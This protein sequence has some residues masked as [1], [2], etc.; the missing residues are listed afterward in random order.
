MNSAP[1]IPSDPDPSRCAA[2]HALGW[3]VSGNTIGMA[4]SVLLLRPQWHPGN[5]SY[6]HWVP[7]HLNAQLYGW[8]ALPLVGWLMSMYET[9]RSKARPWAPAAIW[10]WT[11]ALA[12]SSFRWLE[13]ETSGKIFLDWRNASLWSFLTALII[14]WSVLAVS[15]MD[16]RHSWSK[17]RRF[18]S[19]AGLAIL[20]LVPLAMV[21]AASPETY[22]P[23]DRTTG[24]P[25]GSSLLGSTLL[26]IGLMLL[27][28]RVTSLEEKNRSQRGIWLFFGASWVAFG[29]TEAAGGTHFDSWQLGAMLLLVPWVWLI[30][31]A[32]KRF[33]W[34][35]DSQ[36]W[37]L[38]MLFWW[39]V[40][41]LSGVTMYT[42]GTLDHIKFTQALVAHSHLAMA[43][44]TTS[45]CALL[46]GLVT[47]KSVGGP[48]SISLWSLSVAVM[49][50]VLAVMGWREGSSTEWMIV[51]APWR[52]GG[53]TIRAI[54][55]GVML[56]TSISW[57][58]KFLKR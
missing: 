15:W 32:W 43:G 55:G 5:W 44:F 10:A 58:V 11:A 17:A 37:R 27:L 2:R 24:G 33:S 1:S 40:L 47:G 25:T 52:E 14:L 38:S 53:L 13:G 8:T 57:L 46:I 9:G 16:R 39:A 45:F 50:A 6:G 28:P 51:H 48:V 3:L 34:P 26:V 31:R 49:I 30:P 4:L 54:C 18:S 36:P 35:R 7:L 22:P 41:V 12:L 42:P 19:L 23:V 21:A 29:I 56:G 20:A